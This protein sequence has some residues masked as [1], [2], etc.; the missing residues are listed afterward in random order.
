MHDLRKCLD[1]VIW[2]EEYAIRE[3]SDDVLIVI[4]A[5]GRDEIEHAWEPMA[6]CEGLG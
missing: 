5:K 3:M 1:G 2:S 6:R 4:C